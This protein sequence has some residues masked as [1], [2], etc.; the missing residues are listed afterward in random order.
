MRK[1]LL[2]LLASV[3]MLGATAGASAAIAAPAAAAHVQTAKP[4]LKVKP[5]ALGN[6]DCYY[7]TNVGDGG[8]L[9]YNPSTQTFQSKTV[10]S[11]HY[12]VLCFA[13]G[14]ALFIVEPALT[15][16]MSWYQSGPLG[17][18]VVSDHQCN[19]QNYETWFFVANQNGAGNY[20]SNYDAENVLVSCGFG[21]AM[22]STG[23]TGT[24]V[25]M[26]CT[27]SGQNANANQSWNYTFVYTEN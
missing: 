10:A 21:A 22:D 20:F 8:R 6:G 19:D 17:T 14:D 15:N 13:Q 4:H 24:N 5:R 12:T 26:K 25:T 7:F 23:S 3:A 9:W 11:G 1:L 18:N 2:A 16:C 27:P